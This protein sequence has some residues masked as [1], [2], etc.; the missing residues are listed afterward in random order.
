MLG[1]YANLMN[2]IDQDE[3]PYLGGLAKSWITKPR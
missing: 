1:P 3:D 2:R